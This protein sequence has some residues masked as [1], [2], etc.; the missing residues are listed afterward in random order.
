[1]SAKE[2]NRLQCSIAS[3]RVIAGNVGATDLA[4][5]ARLAC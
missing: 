3:L 5:L 2:V 4:Y 1:M